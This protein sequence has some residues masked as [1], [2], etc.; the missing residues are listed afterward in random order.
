MEQFLTM[1]QTGETLEETYVMGNRM[2]IFLTEYLSNHPGF[3]EPSTAVLRKQS[4]QQLEKLQS[5]LDELALKIDEAQAD[6]FADNFDPLVNE[7]TGYESE[8]EAI[9]SDPSRIWVQYGNPFKDGEERQVDSPTSTVDTSYTESIE[10]SDYSLSD[11]DSPKRRINFSEHDLDTPENASLM[12]ELGTEFLEKIAAE[13]V[14]YETDSEATDSWAQSEHSEEYAR[15]TP[16]ME[17]VVCDPHIIGLNVATDSKSAEELT[18]KVSP[19]RS[20]DDFV[21]PLPR[22]EPDVE[23]SDPQPCPSTHAAE[24]PP[25]EH[26]QRPE[27]ARLFV[28]AVGEGSTAPYPHFSVSDDDQELSHK[29]HTRPLSF[30]ETLHNQRPENHKALPDVHSESSQPPFFQIPA[31]ERTSRPRTCSRES[32]VMSEIEKFLDASFE[33]DPSI[34]FESSME[35]LTR[36]APSQVESLYTSTSPP[37][38]HTFPMFQSSLDKAW[39]HFD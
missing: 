21:G 15:S 3:H 38:T 13:E 18:K 4:F 14:N 23:S 22:F 25:V 17:A 33:Y 28:D 34:V 26:F 19:L 5:C 11:D 32:A 2:V 16:Q 39:V 27:S 24:V 36:R 20:G 30:R 12:V 6:T 8:D 7:S 9:S 29:P 35:R 37:S 10:A 1:Y 31:D